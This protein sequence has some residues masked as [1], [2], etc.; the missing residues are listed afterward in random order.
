VT[1]LGSPPVAPLH[2]QLFW[3]T[4]RALQELGGSGSRQEVSAKAAELGGYS[5]ERQAEL[6]PN[7]RTT[8]IVYHVG[9]NL[10]RLKRIGLADNSQRGVWSLTERGRNATEQDEPALWDERRV[11]YRELRRERLRT[12]HETTED[13]DEATLEGEDEVSWKDVLIAR[14]KAMEPD[15]FE[16][17]C[18]RLF[19]EAGFEKVIVTGRSGDQ[20]IDGV[21]LARLGLLS[22]PTYFQC[23][24]Y[25][26]SVG[27][28]AV[29]GRHGRRSVL[30]ASCMTDCPCGS[31]GGLMGADASQRRGKRCAG[32]HHSPCVGAS[33]RCFDRSVRSLS[34]V[35]RESWN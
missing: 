31:R 11:A 19:R 33:A 14:M 21:G 4:L 13:S 10:T 28:G 7:G 18:Q 30:G 20:G 16:R 26:N 5:E 32:E 27:A 24:R 29:R 34:P 12:S 22:F 9:W 25:E 17:L 6:M 1:D 3:T 8:K 2:R 23:K 35:L 15:A